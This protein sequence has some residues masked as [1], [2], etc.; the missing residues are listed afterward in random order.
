MRWGEVYRRWKQVMEGVRCSQAMG[1]DR[2]GRGMLV[3]ETDNGRRGAARRQGKAGRGRN[4]EDVPR[5]VNT[6]PCGVDTEY[7]FREAEPR[8]RDRSNMLAS[9]ATK[10]SQM[11]NAY[12]Y[13][14]ARS[15][16]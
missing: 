6:E 14:R 10:Y 8:G 1:K 2:L 16:G 7:R 13:D 5:D 4:Q 11:F 12:Y 9:S 15:Y 3:L